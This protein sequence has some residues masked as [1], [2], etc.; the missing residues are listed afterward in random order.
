MPGVIDARLVKLRSVGSAS[1]DLAR[2]DGLLGDVLRVDGSAS[3]QKS[4]PSLRRSPAHFSIDRRRER[5]RKL[6]AFPHDRAEAGA[7]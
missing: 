1:I 2:R 6:E 4:L 5:G 7:A 3:L